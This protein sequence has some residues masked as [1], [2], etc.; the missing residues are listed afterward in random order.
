MPNNQE[1]QEYCTPN[2]M[3][4]SKND[5]IIIDM[6]PF[7][8]SSSGLSPVSAI[9]ILE[10]SVPNTSER[11]TLESP[12]IPEGPVPLEPAYSIIADSFSTNT[13]SDTSVDT[14]EVSS[15]RKIQHNRIDGDYHHP[16]DEINFF[17]VAD[18]RISSNSEMYILWKRC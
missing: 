16:D 11:F 10:L 12:T 3:T 13:S 6:P 14:A 15:I 4:D 1:Q 8:S 2:S 18:K 7:S 17:G 5:H 9:H